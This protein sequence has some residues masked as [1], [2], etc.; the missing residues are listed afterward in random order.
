MYQRWYEGYFLPK[1]GAAKIP[2]QEREE[3]ELVITALDFLI[4]GRALEAA[5]VL[6]SR[7]AY[8]CVGI[9]TGK[10]SMARQM[11]VYKARVHSLVDDKWMLAA[12]KESTKADKQAKMLAACT[13]GKRDR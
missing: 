9:E 13:G 10:W 2:A 6:A 12:L 8:L 1:H 3:F 7:F 11:L 5:D 4:G